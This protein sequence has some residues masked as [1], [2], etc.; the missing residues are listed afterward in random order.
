MKGQ[1]LQELNFLFTGS[2]KLL[3]KR[4]SGELRQAD[5]VSTILECAYT[6]KPRELNNNKGTNIDELNSARKRFLPLIKRTREITGADVT[7]TKPETEA[8][9]HING[10]CAVRMNAILPADHAV[11]GTWGAPMS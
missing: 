6:A 5:F 11:Q 7:K 4:L 10:A 1:L 3:A 2:A 8:A 9:T